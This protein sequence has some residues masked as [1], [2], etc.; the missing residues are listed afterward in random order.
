MNEHDFDEGL[1][2]GHS[3][4]TGMD[5]RDRSGPHVA[6]ASEVTTPSSVFHDDAHQE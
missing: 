3:W 4:A 5:D 2:H 1:V 6:D